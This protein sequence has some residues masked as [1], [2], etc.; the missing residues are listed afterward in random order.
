MTRHETDP[1]ISQDIDKF[2]IDKE[3]F[4]KFIEELSLK[5]QN[6]P[7]RSQAQSLNTTYILYQ[8][9]EDDKEKREEALSKVKG[10]RNK[11]KQ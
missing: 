9:F 10:K 11:R 5:Y 2:G 8:N 7:I 3:Q 6:L 4:N 1:D